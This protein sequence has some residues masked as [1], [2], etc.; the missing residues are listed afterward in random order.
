GLDQVPERGGAML[1][2]NHGILPPEPLIL[3]REILRARGRYLRVVSDRFFWRIPFA[4]DRL[5]MM[6]FLVGTPENA[7]RIIEHGDLLLVYPGGAREAVRPTTEAYRLRWDGRLGFVRTALATGVPIL[8]VAVVGADHVYDVWYTEAQKRLRRALDLEWIAPM[9]R[10]VGLAPRPTHFDITIGAPIR[11]ENP[12][13]ILENDAFVARC[14]AEV[15]TAL[16]TM[17]AEGL[18]RYRGYA[19]P[20]PFGARANGDSRRRSRGRLSAGT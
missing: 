4:R 1:V 14:Q 5:A 18:S 15:K 16:E 9:V 17:L 12:G 10:G 20:W 7:E 8:P 6:G 13:R 3:A 19:G 11:F 2:A